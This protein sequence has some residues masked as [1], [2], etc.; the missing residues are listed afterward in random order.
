LKDLGMDECHNVA[1]KENGSFA[2]VVG[3]NSQFAVLE[4]G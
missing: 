4:I 3:Y 2:V 1:F